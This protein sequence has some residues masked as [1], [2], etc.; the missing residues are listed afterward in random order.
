MVVAASRLLGGICV[1]LEASVPGFVVVKMLGK[2]ILEEVSGLA[3]NNL[4]K[5][6]G[7]EDDLDNISARCA[8]WSRARSSS[9]L[10]FLSANARSLAN[11]LRV[12]ERVAT[13]L[14]IKA[15]EFF[16]L[17]TFFIS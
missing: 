12:V 4:A 13:T 16:D 6:L 2:G 14:I 5:V 9:S 11:T 17:V 3:S 8:Q 10:C 7:V 15:L 1:G